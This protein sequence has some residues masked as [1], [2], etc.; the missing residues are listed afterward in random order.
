MINGM[1]L[2][3][4]GAMCEMARHETVA[5]NL[6]NAN[7]DGFK[8]NF[9]I[10]RDVPAESVIKSAGRREIDVLLE[11]TGGGAWMDRTATD[12]TPGPVINTDNPLHLTIKDRDAQRVSFFMTRAPDAPDGEIRYTRNGS[13][14]R[15]ADGMLVT[16]DGDL[17]LDAA[18]GPVALTASQGLYKVSEDG[19]I[20]VSEDGVANVVVGQVGLA[21]LPLEQ[22]QFGLRQ[23][24]G[25]RYVPDATINFPLEFEV[26]NRVADVQS[27]ML[28]QSATNPVFEMVDMI[29][30][31]RSFEL[32]M[33]FLTMQDQTLGQALSRLTARA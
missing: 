9:S 10:F 21:S 23:L 20:T 19:A 1:Y 32:N 3:T 22:A 31:H 7:T 2:S 24:G 5:N 11:K 4:M 28:E 8:P 25:N 6:A 12:F 26:V 33:R 17:V 30:A 13:F 14:M 29:N 15:R 27:G 16:P 18:G